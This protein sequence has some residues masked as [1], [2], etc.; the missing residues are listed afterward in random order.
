MKNKVFAADPVYRE[1]MEGYTQ[2]DSVLALAYWVLW[3]AVYYFMGQVM[4]R[5]G[6]YYGNIVNIGLMLVAVVLCIRKLSSI[7]I[8]LRNLKPSLLMGLVIGTVVLLAIGIVPGIMSGA[9]LLPFGKILSNVFY[10]VIIIGLAEEIGFRGFIQP[11][12]YPLLKKEWLTVIVGGVLFVLMHIPFQMGARGMSF[13][14]YWPTF[15]ANA[16]I[17]FFW[18]LVSTWLYRRYG[19]IAGAALFHGMLDLSMGIFG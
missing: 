3:M 5:T 4:A 15:I 17:Q 8:T 13:A 18:H 11:R 2:K 7:G 16:P 1:Q 14:E 6:Q 9:S 12:L 10:Y 19:N